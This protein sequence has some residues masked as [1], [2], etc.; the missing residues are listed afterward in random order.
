[1]TEHLENID[2]KAHQILHSVLTQITK[3]LYVL[4]KLLS[5]K[6]QVAN[7]HMLSCEGD[8]S[9]WS[10][11]LWHWLWN[12]RTSVLDSV[13]GYDRIFIN[14]ATYEISICWISYSYLLLCQTSNQS[15]L[16][17]EGFISSHNS[18][19][20]SIMAG[21]SWWPMV[22]LHLQSGCRERCTLC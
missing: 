7:I 6:Y 9:R 19:V 5:T 1:M 13:N 18:S 16:G 22:P 2:L 21:K 4:I 20:L 14:S 12:R 11:V 17:K 8:Y 15:N 3:M 10:Q